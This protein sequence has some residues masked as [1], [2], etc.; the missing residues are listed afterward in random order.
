M[1][2]TQNR[3]RYNRDHLRYPSDVTE[4]EWGVSVPLILPRQRAQV[5]QRRRISLTRFLRPHF[6]SQHLEKKA[7][8]TWRRF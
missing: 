5:S 3:A 2:T 1:W 8:S 7:A 4:E 6:P